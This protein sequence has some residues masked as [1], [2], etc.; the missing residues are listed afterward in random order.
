MIVVAS[1]HD[2]GGHNRIRG[3]HTGNTLQARYWSSKQWPIGS[4]FG[5]CPG[6]QRAKPNRIQRD[7]E[8]RGLHPF[9]RMTHLVTAP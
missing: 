5:S 6:T 8:T 3:S 2:I 9:S 7:V 4:A 1:I